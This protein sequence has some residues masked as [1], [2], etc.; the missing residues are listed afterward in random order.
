MLSEMLAYLTVIADD[1]RESRFLLWVLNLLAKRILEWGLR[2]KFEG[3]LLEFKR[4]APEWAESKSWQWPG[5]GREGRESH[6]VCVT[7]AWRL[8]SGRQAD[9]HVTDQ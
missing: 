8:A 1:T 4:K 2:W 7:L 5:E 9:S 3:S 6:L